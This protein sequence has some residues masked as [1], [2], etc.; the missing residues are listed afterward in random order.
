MSLRTVGVQAWT[1]WLGA[2]QPEI[3]ASP[4][5]TLVRAVE[6]TLHAPPTSAAPSP[7]ATDRSNSSAR[8]TPDVTESSPERGPSPAAFS[9]ATEYQLVVPG[10]APVSV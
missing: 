4:P 2:L 10:A 9:A 7:D 5:W 3:T 1:S 6:L 8:N